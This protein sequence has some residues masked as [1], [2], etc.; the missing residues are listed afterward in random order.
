MT[1]SCAN[2]PRAWTESGARCPLLIPWLLHA[3]CSLRCVHDLP[4]RSTVV[5]VLDVDDAAARI[6]ADIVVALQAAGTPLPTNDIWIAAG[7][8]REGATVLSYDA[9]F[10]AIGRVGSQILSRE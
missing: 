6:H 4:V 1:A 2:H 5:H 9:H 8:A 7:C 3:S 10:A